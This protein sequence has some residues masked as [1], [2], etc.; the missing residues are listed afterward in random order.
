MP[1]VNISATLTTGNE[2]E[3]RLIPEQGIQTQ[4]DIVYLYDPENIN[5]KHDETLEGR[6][7]T[8]H[9][10]KLSQELLDEIHRGGN[11]FVFEFDASSAT[12]LIN[13]NLK[14]KPSVTV[15]DSAETVMTCA[16]EYIDENNIRITFNAPF[17]GTAYLN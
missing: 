8:E 6:G 4:T 14:K 10:L 9:P 11:T 15:V 7:T 1:D 13:H 5:V 2:V 12:W 16:T 3:A 17:K